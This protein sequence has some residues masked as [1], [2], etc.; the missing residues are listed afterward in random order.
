MPFTEETAVFY[1][2]LSAQLEKN[3]P[4]IGALDTLIATHALAQRLILITNNQ[5]EFA[6][7]PGLQMENWVDETT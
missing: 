2:N 7:V 6:R 5:R 4:A 3:G 1:G